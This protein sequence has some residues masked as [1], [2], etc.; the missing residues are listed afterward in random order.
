MLQF[1]KRTE[2]EGLESLGTVAE[3]VGV[4]G[5]YQLASAKNFRGTEKENGKLTRVTI[6][7]FN[8]KGEV[9]SVNCSDAL[10]K[11]LRASKNADELREKIETLGTYP[12]IAIPMIDQET[13][14]P[15][16]DE[17]TG[18]PI[19]M[20]IISYPGGS[21]MSSTSVNVTAKMLKAEAPA[22]TIS[23]EDLVAL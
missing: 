11:D 18:E 19:I 10:S 13:D 6:N 23:F 1:K 17:E 5:S 14:E 4:G 12:I 15:I 8:K 22:R 21:D 2:I 3:T 9:V 16:L 7:L 20:N